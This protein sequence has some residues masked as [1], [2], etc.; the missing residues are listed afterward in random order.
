[1]FLFLK[2]N[3]IT[4]KKKIYWLFITARRDEKSNCGKQNR[5]WTKEISLAPPRVRNPHYK[6]QKHEASQSDL[7]DCQWPTTMGLGTEA[8]VSEK[9]QTHWSIKSLRP[10]WSKIPLIMRNR[11]LGICSLSWGCWRPSRSPPTSCGP[12]LGLLATDSVKVN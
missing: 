5:T 4:V 7:D 12:M 8:A 3:F 11:G 2:A 6:I 10:D 9:K 1:M